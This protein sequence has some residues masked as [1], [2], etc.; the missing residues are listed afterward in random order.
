MRLLCIYFIMISW[1]SAA[2]YQLY[3]LNDGERGTQILEDADF[4]RITIE[5]TLLPAVSME[6]IQR[7]LAQLP[8]EERKKYPHFK[9]LPE[10]LQHSVTFILTLEG[11]DK[12]FAFSSSTKK[13]QV[14]LEANG[15]VVFQPQLRESIFPG[16][17]Q[18]MGD[19][20]IQDLIAHF[21]IGDARISH[22]PSTLKLIKGSSTTQR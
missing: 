4:Y 20:P 16:V 13:T 17:I 18:L 7:S 19:F 1:A 11:A 8:E 2:E 5:S 14:A 22:S 3:Q 15:R 6:E 9:P 12:F 10:Q 21:P